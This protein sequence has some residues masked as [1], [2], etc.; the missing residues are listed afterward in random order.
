MHLSTICLRVESLMQAAA[1]PGAPAACVDKTRRG[2]KASPPR[3]LPPH[4]SCPLND[5]EIWTTLSHIRAHAHHPAPAAMPLAL[6][7]SEP[8][9]ASRSCTRVCKT[10]VTSLIGAILRHLPLQRIASGCRGMYDEIQQE[11]TRKFPFSSITL[12]NFFQCWNE[13]LFVLSMLE[14]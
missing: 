12:F 5:V 1:G 7:A 4:E 11:K 2:G 6:A 14:N 9:P 3:S 10:Y 8:P 13:N